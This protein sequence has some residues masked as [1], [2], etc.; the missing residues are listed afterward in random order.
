MNSAAERPGTVG[1]LYWVWLKC[2]RLESTQFSWLF[3][4]ICLATPS[5]PPSSLLWWRC[6][7]AGMQKRLHVSIFR[8][9]NARCIYDCI[10]QWSKVFQSFLINPSNLSSLH[11]VN[12]KLNTRE[13]ELKASFQKVSLAICTDSFHLGLKSKLR[14]KCY[15]LHL[16]AGLNKSGERC[17]HTE[18]YFASANI[19][20]QILQT[21]GRARPSCLNCFLLII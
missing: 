13:G 15:H 17:K 9:L 21:K 14:W 4:L 8:V 20:I 3:F 2:I 10:A 7:E 6:H 5:C 18:K 16:L 19:E 1:K 11:V 12:C